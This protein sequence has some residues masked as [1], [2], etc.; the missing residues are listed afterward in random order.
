MLWE[1]SNNMN[2]RI[3]NSIRRISRKLRAD[4]GLHMTV[5]LYDKFN[6]KSI[7]KCYIGQWNKQDERSG[8]ECVRAEGQSSESA[9]HEMARQCCRFI[10]TVLKI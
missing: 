3:C 9:A 4:C 7:F 2:N 5:S 1:P 6:D 8:K 10:R